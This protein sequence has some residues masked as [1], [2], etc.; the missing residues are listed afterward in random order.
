[1]TVAF[2]TGSEFLAVTSTL[3]D[4]RTTPGEFAFKKVDKNTLQELERNQT[5]SRC[6]DSAY[7]LQKSKTSNIMR[8]K[9]KTLNYGSASLQGFYTEDNV[10]LNALPS[11]ADQSLAQSLE[12]TTCANFQFV[13]LYEAKGLHKEF[14]GILGLSPRKDPVNNEKHFLWSLKNHGHIE[15]AIVSFSLNQMGMPDTPYA[16]FGG[17]NSS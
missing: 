6:L 7:S 4:D 1:V 13:S 14:S 16:L 5:T 9:S 8:N 3:C 2:D 12:S 11:T 17:F 15:N 10:C